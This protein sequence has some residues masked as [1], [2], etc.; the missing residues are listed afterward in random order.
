MDLFISFSMFNKK[1]SV[2]LSLKQNCLVAKYISMVVCRRFMTVYL[3]LYNN[4]TRGVS[5][6]KETQ[7]L[8]TWRFFF[9][10]F[11]FFFFSFSLG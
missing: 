11:F 7:T 4:M 8:S 3:L 2:I 1:N 9:L 6:R 5:L 10:V